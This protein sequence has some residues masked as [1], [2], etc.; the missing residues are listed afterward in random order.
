MDMKASKICL[1]VKRLTEK[2][3]N[4]LVG[5]PHTYIQNYMVYVNQHLYIRLLI[6]GLLAE[7]HGNECEH[8]MMTIYAGEVL[9][10]SL[11]FPFNF[12][13]L[14]VGQCIELIWYPLDLLVLN[15]FYFMLIYIYEGKYIYQ[16]LDM[17]AIFDF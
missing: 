3:E 6:C 13:L 1:S 2:M 9:Y 14:V 17:Y 12:H 7:F 4:G 5:V 10:F 15:K 16:L 8:H 11:L